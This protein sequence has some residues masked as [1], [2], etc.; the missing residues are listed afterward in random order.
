MLAA[1]GRTILEGGG[2][3]GYQFEWDP[4][5]LRKVLVSAGR[6][7]FVLLHLIRCCLFQAV[8][9]QPEYFRPLRSIEVLHPRCQN[10][11]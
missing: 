6:V 4:V 8:T 5:V 7:R 2:E 3:D 9:G 10:P 1:E 11:R